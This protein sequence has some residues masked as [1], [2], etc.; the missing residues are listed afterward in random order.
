MMNQTPEHGLPATPDATGGD[1]PAKRRRL[2]PGPSSPTRE[3]RVV[4][5][6][7]P[8]R[9]DQRLLAN[10]QLQALDV[11]AEVDGD[12]HPE[13]DLGLW[14]KLACRPYLLNFASK[15]PS[16]EV[17][18]ITQDAEAHQN[19]IKDDLLRTGRALLTL[20]FDARRLIQEQEQ[21]R[22]AKGGLRNKLRNIFSKKSARQHD[23]PRGQQSRDDTG[24]V[25]SDGSGGSW[26]TA[27]S[28]S[29]QTSESAM[30]D[31][32]QSY[33]LLLR[34]IGQVCEKL[35]PSSILFGVVNLETKDLETAVRRLEDSLKV[36]QDNVREI[37]FSDVGL[38][39]TKCHQR[40]E[41]GVLRKL[42]ENKLRYR[43]NRYNKRV[44]IGDERVR[45][46][47]EHTAMLK[48]IADIGRQIDEIMAQGKTVFDEF[49]DKSLLF[50]DDIVHSAAQA[51]SCRVDDV[52]YNDV[53]VKRRFPME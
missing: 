37:G 30:N 46:I 5:N 21:W 34:V 1:S 8:A 9:E 42:E 36:H 13:I 18:R 51:T 16:Y 11:D 2:N 10:T 35:A 23:A 48:I 49:C 19:W 44:K 6:D 4:L 38:A 43:R 27:N 33:T 14:Y 41:E 28:K 40:F 52:L 17:K 15:V 29:S 45:R 25:L 22:M 24:S 47:E 31:V 26:G 3:A 20:E 39:L 7:D 53:L 50:M 12:N 32:E